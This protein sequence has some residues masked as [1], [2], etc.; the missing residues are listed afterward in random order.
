MYWYHIKSCSTGNIFLVSIV[1]RCLTHNLFGGTFLLLFLFL[2]ANIWE[3]KILLLSL[4]FIFSLLIKE[5]PYVL[6]KLKQENRKFQINFNN[7]VTLYLI[8]HHHQEKIFVTWCHS[9]PC[10]HLK[11]HS[12][13]SALAVIICWVKLSSHLCLRASCVHRRQHRWSW[14]ILTC[15]VL[16]CL[17]LIASRAFLWWSSLWRK[18][19]LWSCMV[20]YFREVEADSASSL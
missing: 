2:V 1:T 17:D 7:I 11:N 12:I 5:L 3:F 14:F 8:Y 9:G 13:L 10:I 6:R 16:G 18:T 15:S 4:I 20:S 19:G